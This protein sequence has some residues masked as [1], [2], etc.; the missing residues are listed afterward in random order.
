MQAAERNVRA[1]SL[2]LFG[3]FELR[4]GDGTV[5]LPTRKTRALLA[6]LAVHASQ[7]HSRGKLA[8]LLW[9]DRSEAQ[10]RH[11]LNQA[12]LALR[13]AALD[14]D[15]ELIESQAETVT[16][17]AERMAI[18]VARFAALLDQD[19]AGALEL[20]AGP[21][22]DGLTL[23]E[24][25]FDEWLTDTR[26]HFHDMA[27]R[28]HEAIGLR[29]LQGGDLAAA[30]AAAQ[31]LVELE[32]LREDAHRL[33]MRLQYAAGDRNAALQ[34]FMRLKTLLGAELVVEPGAETEQLH[35]SLREGL[36]PAGST[37][38]TGKGGEDER[39]PHALTAAPERP[40]I[41]VMAFDNLSGDPQQEYFADGVAED[42]ITGLSRF[43]WLLVIARSSS[44]AF[45]G[46]P[47][48]VKRI[49]SELG[50]RYVLC[51]SVRR[52]DNRVRVSVQLA[53]AASG[54]QIWAERYDRVLA[55]IFALQDEIADAIVAAMEP[56][57]GRAEQRRAQGKIPELLG[58]WELCQRGA[59]HL[60][61]RT[62]ADLEAAQ[63]LFERALALDP[64]LTTAWCGLVD[65]YY[66]GI[67][68]GLTSSAERDRELAIVAARRAV[69]A[70]G[71]DA[72]AHCAAGKA[73]LV[74]REHELARPELERALEL[75]P[76]LA[77][78]HYGLG[79]AAIFSGRDPRTAIPHLQQAIR[80]SPR[81][82][83]MGSFMVRLADAY[84]AL[85]DYP[86]AVEW[87]R[88]SLQQPSFQW[89]RYAVLLS[90]LG[91][92]GEHAQARKVLDE[93]LAARADFCIAMVR[94]THL[95]VESETFTHYLEGLGKAGVVERPPR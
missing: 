56:E 32:P 79:A 64:I 88:K 84:L 30:M 76:S 9:G 15:V 62:R 48:D 18:D 4:A 28:G 81:D 70:D 77:W 42:L 66:Y 94:S 82:L 87:A 2:R 89:S 54:A 83:H 55:D 40:S 22:L 92:L 6:F 86:A 73:R 7:P 80:L 37:T 10:A 93:L 85:R 47:V 75:N 11:S 58:A 34:Q 36:P 24:A 25:A 91:H 61:K 72:A 38:G 23:R 51:G 35:R 49:G 63:K 3:G 8:G 16:L 31:R 19:P 46:Q 17:H 50:V 5:V 74:R 60:Y 52:A 57:L 44:F 21:L 53:D 68:L 90:A 27:C 39:Q 95:Y 78:A 43:R 26:R 1:L 69:E 41:A 14:A 71:N 12:L 59:W 20:Y 33:L 65:T 13:R 29:G 67:V 45:K